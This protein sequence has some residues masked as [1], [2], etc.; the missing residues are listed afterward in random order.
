MVHILET[1]IPKKA[2]PIIPWQ[3]EEHIIYN[4]GIK[5]LRIICFGLVKIRVLPSIQSV[6][7]VQRTQD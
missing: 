3:P 7:R 4:A 1:R 2:P 5:D 6:Q